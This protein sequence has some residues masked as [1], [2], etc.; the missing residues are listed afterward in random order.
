MVKPML[1]KV[2]KPGTKLLE[3]CRPAAGRLPLPAGR[4]TGIWN[5]LGGGL[6][7]VCGSGHL[8]AVGSTVLHH[9]DIQTSIKAGNQAQ[10]FITLC[11]FTVEATE[12]AT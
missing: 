4:L 11:L 12:T 2:T 7:R 6:E 9:S 3:P 5:H 8:A 1:G 10:A